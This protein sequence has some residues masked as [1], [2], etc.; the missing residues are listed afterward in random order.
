MKV[1]TSR[2]TDKKSGG[3]YPQTLWVKYPD[4]EPFAVTGIGP[5]CE[6]E[7]FI[8]SSVY[9]VLSGKMGSIN[10][11]RFSYD[12]I[13]PDVDE[14]SISKE[15][16]D[17]YCMTTRGSL[18]NR[19]NIESWWENRNFQY[20]YADL[21]SKTSWLGD[22]ATVTERLHCMYNNITEHSRC[23]VCGSQDVTFQNFKK[24]YFSY[25]SVS[26]ATQ[27]VDRNQKIRDSQDREAIKRNTESWS[28]ERYG[29]KSYFMT[30]EFREKA[31]ATKL[32]KY[33]VE[34]F[35]NPEL[36][37]KDSIE[38]YRVD[39]PL[40]LVEHQAK[41]R[42]AKLEKYGTIV[43]PLARKSKAE[44]DIRQYMWD[45]GFKMYSN[46]KIL[47]NRE[48]DGYSY[49]HNIAFEYCGLYWHCEMNK[50]DNR[51][52]HYDK[53]K[54]C[55]DKGIRLITIFEDEWVHRKDQ[56]KQF[57]RA[58]FGYFERRIFARKCKVVEL[59]PKDTYSFFEQ[60]HIQGRPHSSIKTFGLFHDD[61][62]VGCV[63]YGKHHRNGR[64]IVLNRL[65][66]K[67]D[68]QIVGGAS[69]LIKNTVGLFGVDVI[70]WSDNRWSTGEL[71]EKAGFAFDVDL[72]PDY[73]YVNCKNEYVRIPKQSMTK[74]AIG[75]PAHIT[76]K[77]FC[78]SL[79]YYQ[80]HDC[81]KKRFIYRYNGE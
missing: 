11:V 38:K 26:C 56:V 73:S 53:Y 36:R 40:K 50:P 12:P 45:L 5:F 13:F 59:N 55:K 68:V 41:L 15:F 63:S 1:Y 70:T 35:S 47:G 39:T 78:K 10:G 77:E 17:T 18:N 64:Q 60:Y 16:I 33:G 57:L 72:P 51:L 81:G 2:K 7:G 3:D 66:F 8:L 44:G 58:A 25:C 22:Q 52:Y 31:R 71:Y 65:A 43:P 21:I 23:S 74:R 24:G 6:Q 46:R 62:L 30:Q 9:K 61:E 27:S 42:A 69:K 32:L 80:I 28:L 76:E 75:C 29:V 37:M 49:T 4:G 79:G 19:V 48:L 34:S 14:I 67:S 54:R 20:T